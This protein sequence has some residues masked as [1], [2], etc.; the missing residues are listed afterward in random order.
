[1][2]TEPIAKPSG[3][4]S[5]QPDVKLNSGPMDV[6]V[7]DVSSHLKVRAEPNTRSSVLEKLSNGTELLSVKRALNGNWQQ[8]VTD[9][10]TIGYVS[11]DYLE[12]ISDRTNC[13]IK[14]TV[15]TESGM[16]VN[17]R[18]GPSTNLDIIRSVP[19]GTEVTSI[20][21][22]KYYIGGIS[23]DRVALNDGTQAFISSEYLK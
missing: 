16:G 8:V 20:N 7:I 11:G 17:A 4:S 13:N 22:G 9:S 10:G 3:T 14:K 5:S 18:I 12:F 1:M 19:S 6:R 23:W 15:R 2:P 21:T